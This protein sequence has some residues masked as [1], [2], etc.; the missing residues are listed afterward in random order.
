MLFRSAPL[1]HSLMHTL[2]YL[3][4]VALLA[5]AVSAQGGQTCNA[6]SACSNAG[7]PC[8]SEF[9]F[10]GE[11]HFCLGGCNPMFS[12]SLDSC[13]PAPVC[14]DKKYVFSDNSRILTNN[15]FFDGN[16][17]EYDWVV[18]QG[19][20]MNTNSS[21]GE[22]VLTLTEANKGT[23]LSSTRYVHYGTI[24]ARMKTARSAGIV[25]AFITMSDVKDE[26][27]WEFP[28]VKTTEGQSNFFWQGNVPEKSNGG[29]H[30]TTDTF[31]NYHDF[32]IDW[33]QDQL[34][35]LIDGQVIRT[36]KKSDFPGK[37][38]TT[39]SRIQ[40]SIWPAGAEGMAAGTIEWAGGMIDYND[41]DYKAQ[42]HF[43][44]LF[45]SIEVK[46]ADPTKPGPNDTSYIYTNNETIPGVAISNASTMLNGVVSAI[47]AP[48]GLILS[49]AMAAVFMVTSFMTL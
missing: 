43:A 38:P 9:G 45:Q 12:R 26:I 49:S 2:T 6:T 41:P 48:T 32:G 1:A 25:T 35:W 39:P 19:N 20:I 24:T 11:E 3:V 29:Y 13:R 23:R 34:S 14:Q 15:T 22:L 47:V 18:E 44:A 28:G 8:C 42:G 31:S 17:T 46:C 7:A 4:P 10:C 5:T 21:G 16:A 27:D 40:M 37:Y 30:E 36:V 33:Q